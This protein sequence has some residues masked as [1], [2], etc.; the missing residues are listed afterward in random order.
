[1]SS[2][3]DLKRLA[4]ATDV[5]TALKNYMNTDSFPTA[6]WGDVA[7]AFANLVVQ[8]GRVDTADEAQELVKKLALFNDKIAALVGL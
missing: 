3:T 7:L 2:K 6:E 1:M 4:L 5:E 8:T